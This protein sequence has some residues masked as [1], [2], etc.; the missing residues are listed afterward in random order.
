M[1]DSKEQSQYILIDLTFIIYSENPNAVARG[2]C[3]GLK[4]YIRALLDKLKWE[5]IAPDMLDLKING[6]L[7]ITSVYR[8]ILHD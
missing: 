5:C 7:Q 8:W 3:K 2:T 1:L 6:W 4:R